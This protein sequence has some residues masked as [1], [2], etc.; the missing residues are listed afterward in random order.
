MQ[1]IA[2]KTQPAPHTARGRYT[3]I[4]PATAEMLEQEFFL[5]VA[6]RVSLRKTL[7]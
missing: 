1:S 4:N 3:F 7:A 2:F 5:K 6:L